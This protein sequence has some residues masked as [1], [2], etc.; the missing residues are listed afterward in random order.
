MNTDATRRVPADPSLSQRDRRKQQLIDATL[1]CISEYGLANTTLAQVAQ[2]A[3]LSTGLVNF[4]FD[5][6][7][8][9]LL[10]TLRA[11]SREYREAMELAFAF[12]D[13]PAEVLSDV[14]RAHFAAQ[15]CTPEKIAVWYAFSGESRARREYLALCREHDD[16]F[17]KSLLGVVARLCRQAADKR[18]NAVAISRG[19]EGLL[20]GYWQD[21]LYE[22][23]SFDP[24]AAI[25][26]CEDYL[27]G[28]FGA[29]PCEARTPDAAPLAFERRTG[30]LLA[31]WTYRSEEFLQL[32]R[33]HLFHKHWLLAGHLG[34]LPE[35]RDY[36][37]F[38]AL[39]ER[40]LVVRGDDNRVRAFHNVC[41]HRGAKLVEGARGRCR[42][43]LTC[44]F[45]GW[46]YRLDGRLVGVPAAE[47]FENL[48]KAEN[49]LVP[50]PMEIWMGF[51][52]VHF[53]AAS[54]KPP[55]LAQTM[56]PV[57][58]LAALYQLHKMKP[59]ENSRFAELRPYNWKVIH[60]IDNEGYHV[61]NGHPALQQLYGNNYRDDVIDH[62][63]VSYAYLN[64]QPGTLW[65][66]RHYQKLLPTFA[67][68]PPEHQRLWLY[69]GL[70]PNMVLALYPDS[71]EFYMTIPV[72]AKS[73]RL[74]GGAY[75]LPDARRAA[76]AAQYLGARINR[77]TY[78]E[79]D[80]F[81]RRLQYGM[82]SSAF[83]QPRL[84][85][86]EQGV[87]EFHREIQR[88]LPVATLTNQPRPGTLA[89]VNAHMRGERDAQGA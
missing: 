73:T 50:L 68:L 48:D 83:P 57:A 30:D 75:A 61:P 56:K 31:P 21:F 63:A 19:L 81:V 72:D 80:E 26:I 40:A 8:R 17:Q 4:Y 47:T 29:T 37:T 70:F 35:P 71:M 7:K 67:H 82:T 65:S 46:T 54:V 84:S 18:F 36:L 14:I 43:A 74:M 87:R 38:D 51:V 53:G 66:V 79:D 28:F 34:D 85:S 55:S 60:D 23:A 6:K 86:I 10:D 64:E 52:F 15:I 13:D 32:E 41:R 25:A 16:W 24:E 76:R 27:S 89:Q 33:A 77:V 45:H 22:P 42:R 2:T 3:G 39:G 78:R 20:D 49:G 88:A 12:S 1:H 59:I 58:H 11:L 62:V 69:I 9:L 44:P 5:N